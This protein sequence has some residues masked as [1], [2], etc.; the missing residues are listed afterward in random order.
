MNVRLERARRLLLDGHS[1][2]NA[3]RRSGFGTDETLRRAFL[4]RFDATPTEYR[5]RFASTGDGPQI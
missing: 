3:A 4:R 1:V 5:A 2:M